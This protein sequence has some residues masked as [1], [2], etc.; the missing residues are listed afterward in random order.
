MF[1]VFT[2]R[3]DAI[4]L[5]HYRLSQDTDNQ[6]KVFAVITK[7]KE[8]VSIS[9]GIDSFL[10]ISVPC[11]FK[12][13]IKSF[14]LKYSWFTMLYLIIKAFSIRKDETYPFII[15]TVTQ[16]GCWLN[17]ISLKRTGRFLRCG[18]FLSDQLICSP[19]FL[20]WSR[21]FKNMKM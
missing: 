19:S 9:G 4:L 6:T 1:F 5:G 18:Y 8:E 12:S 7:K 11:S 15:Y 14:F 13:F 10:L 2:F 17:S 3:T 20:F 16:N 21:F